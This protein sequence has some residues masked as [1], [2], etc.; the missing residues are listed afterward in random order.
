MLLVDY[1]GAAE[2]VADEGQGRGHPG[3]RVRPPVRGRRLLRVVRQRRRSASWRARRSSTASRP[4]ARTRPRPSSSTWAA[5]RPTATPRCSTTAPSRSWRPPASSRPPS[6]RESGTRPSPQTN[7][8]Q[9]LT[10]LGGKVD[11]RVGR[12]RH[13]RGRRHQGPAGQQ[14]H[15]CCRSRVRTPT[16][17]VCRTSCSASRPP[18]STSRSRSRPTPLSTLAIAL[19]KGETPDGRRRSSTTARRTSQVTPILVG[20][21]EV[22]DVV[23][24]GDADVRRR[25]HRRRR[26]RVRR[27]HGVAQ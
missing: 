27:V 6:P 19:L 24:A 9:A 25:L 23:A 12:Q 7:F 18:P 10:S 15:R 22:K 1:Q 4:P 11:A 20:P 13:Q 14:P 21:D 8:E 3:H 5:T 16:S 2:A 26:R 17:R